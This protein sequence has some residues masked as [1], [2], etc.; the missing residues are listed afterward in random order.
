MKYLPIL[1]SL[2]LLA[3]AEKPNGEQLFTMNCAA[4]HL[5]DQ[6]LVGPSLVEI[7]SLYQGKADDFLKWCA[8][9]QKK[10]PN[11]VDM[12]S[13][14][15]V[16]N[17]GL[18]LIYDHIMKVSAGLREVQA[19]KGDPYAAS[20]VQTKRPQIQR[21]FMPNA[22]PA[23]M[24][25]ALDEQVSVCWDAGE[26]RLRYAW[27]GGFID[28]YPYWQGNGS[29]LASIIGT[30]RYTEKASP[31]REMGE[32]RFSGYRVDRGLPILRYQVGD[33]K[34]TETFSA[35]PNA[36]GFTRTFT[37]SPRSSADLVLDFSPAEKVV[38]TSD[39]G[40]WSNSK[41]TLKAADSASFTVTTTFK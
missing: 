37:L 23:A 26:C 16:G 28:G 32:V 30:V 39:K 33:Q 21:I 31:F 14:V 2:S 27:T 36:A 9:P 17:D 18:L 35:L 11:A 12:P 34:I 7:R 40:T 4:C 24:A 8:A 15:H 13:M 29:S 41:L 19:K 20:P 3:Y 5:P 1:L 6:M 38:F 22:G 10:R 25:V